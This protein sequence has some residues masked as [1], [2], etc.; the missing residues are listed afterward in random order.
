MS[1]WL[2]ICVAFTLLLQGCCGLIAPER[3]LNHRPT[4]A[5]YTAV[6]NETALA[7]AL[8]YADG[9]SASMDSLET[10][11]S[12]VRTISNLALLG[13]TLGAASVAAFTTLRDPITGLGLGGAGILGLEYEFGYSARQSI[14]DNAR[15]AIACAEQSAQIMDEQDPGAIAVVAASVAPGGPVMAAVA[16]PLAGVPAAKALVPNS[17]ASTN[18]LSA[19]AYSIR[20]V[21]APVAAVAPPAGRRRHEAAVAPPAPEPNLASLANAVQD[22]SSAQTAAV[23]SAQ[24]ALQNVKVKAPE[25]LVFT[26]RNI[27]IA[28]ITLLHQTEPKG[29]DLVNFVNTQTKNATSGAQQSLTST[30]DT[31]DK[32]KSTAAG[33][34]TVAAAST[35]DATKQNQI[36]QN[37]SATNAN[38][39]TTSQNV[40]DIAQVLSDAA[41]CKQIGGTA[42]VSTPTNPPA[43]GGGS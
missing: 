9:V 35:S 19:L 40:S 26:V 15:A 42:L 30:K 23:A 20:Q 24:A 1:K 38:L 8:A 37:G 6:G 36:Q 2:P 16:P 39:K 25:F 12:N 5:N 21:G 27:E 17:N 29:Q 33:A 14:Y 43:S 31:T 22:S 28:A 32:N 4:P 34:T 41:E 3:E 13:A 10:T 7:N 18:S 11:V